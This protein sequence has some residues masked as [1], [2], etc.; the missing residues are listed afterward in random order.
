MKFTS[1]NSHLAIKITRLS[2][3]DVPRVQDL[4]GRVLV[5]TFEKNQAQ[6]TDPGEIDSEVIQKVADLA[7][8]LSSD[9]KDAYHLLV[10]TPQGKVVGIIGSGSLNQEILSNL[11]K[12][13]AQSAIEIK[14]VYVDPDFQG[15]GI[16]TRLFQKML[17][18]LKKE[19]VTEF[20]LD[21]GFALAQKYWSKK[22]GQ[23]LVTKSDY[24]GKGNH[25]MIW[26][27]SVN[28]LI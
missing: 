26:K 2:E 18:H 25:Y 6:L 16:G 4:L 12:S 8:D 22:L 7:A 5:D 21:S 20:Y 11:D 19:G 10:R 15:M 3:T 17:H 27:C 1:D 9:G 13:P 28:Q 24:Y 23:P 14:N